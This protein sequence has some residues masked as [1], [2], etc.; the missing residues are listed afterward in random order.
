M[1]CQEVP[2]LPTRSK[3]RPPSAQDSPA[4]AFGSKITARKSGRSDHRA[5]APISLLST[6]VGVETGLLSYALSGRTSA[7]KMSQWT[8]DCHVQSLCSGFRR[9]AN[10]SRS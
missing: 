7:W 10:L 2:V 5:C 8:I 1:L 3:Q 4:H 6:K 9:I